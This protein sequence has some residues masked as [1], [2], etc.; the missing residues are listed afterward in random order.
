MYKAKII[1][2][3]MAV[4]ECVVDNHLLARCFTTSDEWITQRTGIKERRVS[5]STY[6]FLRRLAAAP[7]KAACLRDFYERGIDGKIDSELTP[8]DL[9]REAAEMALKNAG[10]QIDDVDFIVVT[11]TIPEYAYPHT[12]AVISAKF[13]LTSTPVLNLQQGCSGFLYALAVA[14]AF[15]RSGTYRRVLVI[16]AEMLST[17]LEY[18][19]RGRDMAVLF[20]DGAGA[21]VLQ[22]VHASSRS[23]LISHHL[24]QDGT[25]LDKLYGEIYGNST[26]PIVCKKKIDD[27]RAK[28]TM[29]GR[30]VFAQAVRRFKEVLQETLQANALSAEDID[31][32]LFHQANQRILDSIAEHAKIPEH[33][34]F[35]NVHRYGNT[36]AASV[37]ICIHEAFAEGRIKEGDLVLTAAFGAGF[38]WGASLL[39][40]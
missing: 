10:L 21:V 4:P 39:R 34:L 17:M 3:G 29:N 24:H 36:S 33:K 16:G 40:W 37:P 15:I 13:G 35:N 38:A 30:A 32:F 6:R 31:L 28:P 1:G 14:D 9:G 23:G 8:S 7:D 22:A 19:D 25:V 5:P 11:T 12:G 26:Y 18:S 20:A 27:G 2:T